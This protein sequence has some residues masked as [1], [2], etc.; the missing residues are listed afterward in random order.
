MRFSSLPLLLLFLGTTGCSF[1]FVKPSKEPEPRECTSSWAA[2]IVDSLL[3]TYQLVGFIVAHGAREED[4]EG[5]RLTREGDMLFGATFAALHLSSAVYG[6]ALTSDCAK[7]KAKKKKRKRRRR[8]DEVAEP[9][10]QHSV[11]E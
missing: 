2:P 3:G 4:Y 5:E 8:D 11:R 10:S 6:Y 7:Q 1:L 9:P